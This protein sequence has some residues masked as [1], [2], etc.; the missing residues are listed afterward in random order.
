M[1]MSGKRY[2]IRILRVVGTMN[3]AH[4]HSTRS[5]RMTIKE[6]LARVV[7]LGGMLIF[8]FRWVDS[9]R[10]HLI[11]HKTTQNIIYQGMTIDR[12]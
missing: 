11:N 6:M 1:D 12:T 5:I 8:G 10:R 9:H 3:M 4:I 2:H 7:K